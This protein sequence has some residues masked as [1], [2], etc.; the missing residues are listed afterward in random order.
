MFFI[1][2]RASFWQFNSFIRNNLRCSFFGKRIGEYRFFD[3]MHRFWKQ[4]LKQSNFGWV[5][6]WESVGNF[7]FQGNQSKM[8]TTRTI[9]ITWDFYSHWNWTFFELNLPY[10]ILLHLIVAIKNQGKKIVQKIHVDAFTLLYRLRY[11]MFSWHSILRLQ[12][13]WNFAEHYPVVWSNRKTSQVSSS[14]VSLET[15]LLPISIAV[16]R[17]VLAFST[18]SCWEHWVIFWRYSVERAAMKC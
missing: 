5:S 2:L 3:M 7:H 16:L 18:L 8:E 10:V 13:K 14:K 1:E 12:T 11:N 6:V 4:F 17:S 15:F 9:D